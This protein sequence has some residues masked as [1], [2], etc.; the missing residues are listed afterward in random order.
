[1]GGN[2]GGWGGWPSGRTSTIDQTVADV[3]ASA[4][5]DADANSFL[6]ELLSD[7]NNRDAEK[8][9][10][11]IETLK[12]VI[13]KEIDGE[14]EALFGG[15]VRKHTYVDGLS[16]IDVLMTINDSSLAN[17]TPSEVLT[18]FEKRITQRLGGVGVNIKA[19]TL[20]VTVR[21]SDG[22]EIQVLPALRT[23]SGL[24]IPSA[25]GSGW[26]AVVRPQ[27]FAEKLTSINQA[28]G[29]KVVPVIKLFKG[30]QA[31]QPKM[32]QLKGYHIESLAIEAFRIGVRVCLSILR[33]AIYVSGLMMSLFFYN[34]DRKF[35]SQ[36]ALSCSLNN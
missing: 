1:M 23:A 34:L 20:A 36:K 29:G 21:Y 33:E 4:T 22:T 13:D 19:G 30:L 5:Y 9:K 2:G 28:N 12:Q 14:T 24:K 15:S 11:H 6:Q 31:Q 10:K 16:D 7:Y 32:N 3:T 8:I 35:R 18:Y 17:A 25:D 26:S 27:R